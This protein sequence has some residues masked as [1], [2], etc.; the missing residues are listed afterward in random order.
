MNRKMETRNAITV[1]L[2]AAILLAGT[3]CA[4]VTGASAI[5]SLDTRSLTQA[6]VAEDENMDT[7]SC[8]MDWSQETRLNT[9]KI[10]G[11]LLLVL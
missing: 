8:T 2:T 11:T 7:R 10:V 4:E 5:T 1:L 6:V 9:K 3:I